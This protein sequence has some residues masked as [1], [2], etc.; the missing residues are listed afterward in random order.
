MGE[1]HWDGIISIFC[2]L[3]P[4]LRKQVH[5]KVVR[6]LKQDG[7]FLL[8][9]YTPEQLNYGTGGGNSAELMQSKRWLSS[10]LKGLSFQHLLGLERQVIEGIYHTGMAAVVQAIGKKI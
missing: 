4:Y 10:E 1:T 9:A 5:E 7:V 8:E 3:Q 6:G 2:P